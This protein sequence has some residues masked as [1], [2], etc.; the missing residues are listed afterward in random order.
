M[1]KKTFQGRPVVPQR[2]HRKKG[3]SG[4]GVRV[5]IH[6]S[7]YPTLKPAKKNEQP[8]LKAMEQGKI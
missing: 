5:K 2:R 6:A 8:V 7:H 4:K 3:V 1:A